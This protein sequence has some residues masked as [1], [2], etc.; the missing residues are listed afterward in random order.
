MAAFAA[1]LAQ[2]G[3]ENLACVLDGFCPE[4]E[5][6]LHPEGGYGWCES[7]GHGYRASV[8]DGSVRFDHVPRRTR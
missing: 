8:V 1:T 6:P 7:C 5:A 4:C 2:E 3:R